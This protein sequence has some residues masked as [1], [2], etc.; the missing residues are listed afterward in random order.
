MDKPQDAFVVKVQKSLST[1][2]D[3]PSMLIY[4]ASKKV[5]QQFPLTKAWD[6]RVEGV[7]AFY[8]AKLSKSGKVELQG[9]ALEPDDFAQELFEH[10]DY[11]TVSAD[12]DYSRG[13]NM[14]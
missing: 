12:I 8:W 10:Y 3:K 2:D 7:K 13:R 5:F 1:S 6:K 9:D 4:D 11:V 14:K